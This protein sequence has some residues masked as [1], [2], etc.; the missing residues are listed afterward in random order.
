MQKQLA[1]GIIRLP[2]VFTLNKS[3]LSIEKDT[4]FTVS[5]PLA[6][7]DY[8]AIAK[9]YYPMILYA[10][11]NLNQAIYVGKFNCIIQKSDPNL[12]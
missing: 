11:M 1:A 7:C 6:L 4:K 8:I 3:N 9:F 12:L 2:T 10:K 5:P